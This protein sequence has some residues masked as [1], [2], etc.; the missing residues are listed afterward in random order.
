MADNLELV[1]IRKVG[2]LSVG[3]M[4]AFIG[5]FTGILL[6][7]LAFVLNL[8]FGSHLSVAGLTV[9]VMVYIWILLGS[10]L[11]NFIAGLVF[12]LFYNL[13]A[14]IVNGVKLYA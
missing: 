6:V 3:G 5:L 2:V 10:V 11:I 7:I 9:G 14:M 12:G 8:I 13:S 1:T 4:A